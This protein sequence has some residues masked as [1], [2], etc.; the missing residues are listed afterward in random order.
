MNLTTP[1][2]NDCD[3]A[4]AEENVNDFSKL[5]QKIALSENDSRTALRKFKPEVL[6]ALNR[7]E[8]RTLEK[9]I[10]DCTCIYR[11]AGTKVTLS[12]SCA[13]VGSS[14]TNLNVATNAHLVEAYFDRNGRPKPGLESCQFANK[15]GDKPVDLILSPGSYSLG[16][17]DSKKDPLNDRFFVKLAEKIPGAKEIPI[18][19]GTEVRE[20]MHVYTFSAKQH[21]MKEKLGKRDIVAQECEVIR[22]LPATASEPG[23]FMSNCSSTPGSSGSLNVVRD[24]KG[25]LSAI[26]MFRGGMNSQLDGQPV[27]KTDSQGNVVLGKDGLPILNNVTVSLTMDSFFLRD[28]QVVESHLG[29]QMVQREQR[30]TLP[31]STKGI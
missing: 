31:T 2:T 10:G 24:E 29:D 4:V 26:G 27:Y 21:R 28:F 14:G 3:P 25:Q 20:G 15:F 22:Y 30:S 17:L 8:I 16:T 5:V 23:A 9:A 12:A 13:L 1:E 11:E 6:P 18:L 7:E 19:R